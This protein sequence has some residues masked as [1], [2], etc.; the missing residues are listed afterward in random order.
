MADKTAKVR[1]WARGHPWKDSP[2]LFTYAFATLAPYKNLPVFRTEWAGVHSLRFAVPSVRGKLREFGFERPELLWLSD[3]AQYSILDLL[4]AHKTVLHITDD[5]LSF[6]T[7]PASFLGVERWAVNR[8]D[9]VIVP[10]PRLARLIRERHAVAERKVLVVPHAVTVDP[11]DLSKLPAEFEAIPRPRV[12]Y[13]GAL[14][15]WLDWP[16]MEDAVERLPRVSFVF[17]GSSRLPDSATCSSIERLRTRGNVFFLGERAHSVAM[18]CVGASDAGIIP[19]QAPRQPVSELSAARLP[20][21]DAAAPGDSLRLTEYVLPMKL[22]E[23][24]ALG[25]PIVSTR[26]FWTEL[27]TKI[28]TPLFLAADP[29]GFTR[30]IL[31]ALEA[32]ANIPA[33]RRRAGLAFARANSWEVRFAPL[34]EQLGF[35]PTIR[36]LART[37]DDRTT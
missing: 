33:D 34:L 30:A 9:V 29:A 10:N 36:P 27:P 6:S 37:R 35:S 3:I 7:T 20:E 18:A 26:D 15:D 13:L 5:Y 2:G 19:F 1:M 32:G 12:I 24:A 22:F 21:S 28:Q 8:A 14:E 17:I 11:E 23:Y 25:L 31:E 16:L 4:V